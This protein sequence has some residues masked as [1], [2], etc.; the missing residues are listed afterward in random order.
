[1]EASP[2]LWLVCQGHR[3]VK[4]VSRC[5]ITWKHLIRDAEG[6]AYTCMRAHTHTHTHTRAQAPFFPPG[7]RPP[8]EAEHR[9]VQGDILLLSDPAST[10]RAAT[11]TIG[12]VRAGQECPS[13]E[14]PLQFS[15]ARSV[16]ADLLTSLLSHRTKKPKLGLA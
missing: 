9:F 1:M 11:K 4:G 2:A 6:Q 13:A 12:P 16:P 10:L 5:L 7:L 3:A 14:Y 15:P 8:E